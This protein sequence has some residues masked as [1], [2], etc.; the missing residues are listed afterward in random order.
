LHNLTIWI[1]EGMSR[2][3]ALSGISRKP[4]SHTL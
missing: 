1:S 2:T 3:P 4:Q